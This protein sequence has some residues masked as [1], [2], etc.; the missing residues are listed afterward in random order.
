[1]PASSPPY[2]IMTIKILIQVQL[3]WQKTTDFFHFS[4]LC[5]EGGRRTLLAGICFIY[6]NRAEPI[7]LSWKKYCS[8]SVS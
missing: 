7:Q 4:S 6:P 1:M 5:T 8:I 2:T 3:H